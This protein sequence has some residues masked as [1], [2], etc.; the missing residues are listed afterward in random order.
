MSAGVTIGRNGRVYRRKFDWDEARRL[1]TAGVSKTQLAD[2][3][4]VSLA[5]VQR[6]LDPDA[7]AAMRARSAAW[8]MAGTCVVCGKPGVS[9]KRRD[10]RKGARCV[11]CAA[12]A[13]RTCLRFDELGEIAEIRCYI[14]KAWQPPTAFPPKFREKSNQHRC[15]ACDTTARRA[16]RARKKT[17]CRNCGTPRIGDDSR[18]SRDTG[19]C[20]ACYATPS[21]KGQA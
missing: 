17:P 10:G 11:G 7:R 19:L 15:T 14:C 4:D 9:R 2:R 5:A 8:Q 13:K 18:R 1:H 21:R 6:V 3:Y 16:Y 12:D 20:H